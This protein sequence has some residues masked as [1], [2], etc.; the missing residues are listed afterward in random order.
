MRRRVIGP[1]ELPD[2]RMTTCRQTRGEGEFRVQLQCTAQKIQ[3]RLDTRA[4]IGAKRHQRLQVELV[5]FQIGGGPM[6]R[7]Q[8]LGVLHRKLDHTGHTERHLV[9]QLEHFLEAA[10]EAIGP[11][12]RLGG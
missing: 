7:A 6:G 2:D 12:L 4:R 11:N 8:H 9:L 3:R 1:L 5:A 10:V